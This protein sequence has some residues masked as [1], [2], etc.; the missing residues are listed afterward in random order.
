MVSMTQC[1]ERPRTHDRAHFAAVLAAALLLLFPPAAWATSIVRMIELPNCDRHAAQSL[2][3]WQ[4]EVDNP[5]AVHTPYCDWQKVQLAG[6]AAAPFVLALLNSESP[7][8][9]AVAVRGLPH[10]GARK[11]E[12]FPTVA[13]WLKVEAD[14]SAL[15]ALE[16]LPDQTG[17]RSPAKPTA[18]VLAAALGAMGKDAASALPEL[19]SLA[20]QPHSSV[21]ARSALQA[22]FQIADASGIDVA[23]AL[24]TLLFD[25][26][27]SPQLL[28]AIETR[29]QAYPLP[30]VLPAL[31]DRLARE[32][33]FR[34]IRVYVDTEGANRA[35]PF[36]LRLHARHPALRPGIA[37][38]LDVLAREG[39]LDSAL[40]A[41]VVLP[42]LRS[43]AAPAIKPIDTALPLTMAAMTAA[44]S[45][46][47]QAE[48]AAGDL[49]SAARKERAAKEPLLALLR[50]T[51]VGDVVRRDSFLGAIAVTGHGDE[52]PL[53]YLL[54]ALAHDAAACDRSL[55]RRAGMDAHCAPSKP[56]EMLAAR[57]AIPQQA[58][59]R[60]RH[61]FKTLRCHAQVCVP[62]AQAIAN[63]GTRSALRHLYGEVMA[64]RPGMAYQ[65]IAA[66]IGRHLGP[67]RPDL[68]R[69]LPRL[70]DGR[71]AL[72][73]VMWQ[74]AGD[75][76]T[77]AAHRHR[78]GPRLQAA[79][80]SAGRDQP[81]QARHGSAQ[82]DCAGLPQAKGAL[83][84]FRLGNMNPVVTPT[85]ARSL[86]ALAAGPDDETARYALS[87]LRR[88][89]WSDKP[90]P[91][92][93]A[94]I[95]AASAAT[96]QGRQRA[97]LES[98]AK[99]LAR[100]ERAGRRFDN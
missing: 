43:I 80:F 94:T 46:P 84:L 77:Y 12:A 92:E 9:R 95:L 85:I 86:L 57:R 63:V 65:E 39:L 48:A 70:R 60:L 82:L 10:I 76:A 15:A 16:A 27:G 72:L 29:L 24:T 3:D 30:A 32:D 59:P 81:W 75:N 79:L 83:A 78:T 93:S 1:I 49:V 64:C 55:S 51:L 25:P 62:V 89:V 97:R 44:L 14:P 22:Y 87:T 50:A 5:R 37:F 19:L 47:H 36:L 42:E 31:R 61:A 41:A 73:E 18:D 23:P 17:W 68:E 6:E 67:I 56:A 11:H 35:I 45:D 100:K 13:R 33:G 7:Y 74:S 52:V 34:L 4:R 20:R 21:A 2:A 26:A 98:L 8:A 71:R 96:P 90:Q 91:L 53:N 69:D 38:H 88:I 99:D 40:A 28:S 58:L 66:V 54:D